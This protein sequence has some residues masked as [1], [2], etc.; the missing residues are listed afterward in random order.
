MPSPH[1]GEQIPTRGWIALWWPWERSLSLVF[2]FSCRICSLYLFRVYILDGDIWDVDRDWY[3]RALLLLSNSVHLCGKSNDQAQ[4]WSVPHNFWWNI[5]SEIILATASFHTIFYY[6]SQAASYGE[7][8]LSLTRYGSVSSKQPGC[9]GPRAGTT[10][11]GSV[12]SVGSE[13]SLALAAPSYHIVP[14]TSCL[15]NGDL[16]L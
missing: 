7:K 3:S 13:Q 1:S 14:K 4:F 5:R 10:T 16:I 8:R 12:G 11:D 2:F 15:N 6:T 9:S